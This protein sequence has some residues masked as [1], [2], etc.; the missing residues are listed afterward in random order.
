MTRPKKSP[1]CEHQWPDEPACQ[2]AFQNV[3]QCDDCGVTWDDVYSCGC[4]DECP[5][6]GR[7]YS[8]VGST[9][10]APC[11]CDDLK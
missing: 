9:E 6:C 10:I 1:G 3:Y 5:E 11:A 8:P 7:D 4:D 2:P